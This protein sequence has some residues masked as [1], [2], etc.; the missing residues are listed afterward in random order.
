MG[1][2]SARQ[3]TPTGHPG[4]ITER[5]DRE[6]FVKDL[7]KALVHLYDPTIL[8]H[9]PLVQLFGLHQRR[10]IVSALRSTL[11]DAIERLRPGQGV[12][13]GSQAWRVYHVL[14]YRFT[15]QLSQKEV[16]HDMGLSVRQLRRQENAGLQVLAD[17]LWRLYDLHV[18]ESTLGARPSE[19][20]RDKAPLGAAT[21]S[22]EQEL[23]WLGESL[24]R[25][26]AELQDVVEAALATVRPLLRKAR[27]GVDCTLPDNMPK[28]DVQVPV[29]RQ[30]LVNVLTSAIR[31]ARGGMIHVRAETDKWN[32]RL[33]IRST[34]PSDATPAQE[35]D[36]LEALGMARQLLALFGGSIKVLT[37]DARIQPFAVELSIPATGQ[38]PVLV[39]EDNVDALQL[40]QRCLNGTRYRFVGVHDP[41]RALA[42]AVDS[43]C[44]AIVLDV[45]LPG[46]DGWELMG[47]LRT[48]PQT[49]GVP[50][51]V[52]T[53]LPQEELALALGAAAFIRKPVD[54]LDLLS[55]LDRETEPVLRGSR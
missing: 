15:E 39:I 53:V 46:V 29:L 42:L 8:L 41:E 33:K 38:I 5:L 3:G 9:S 24:P 40:F 26:P 22:R 16:A 1:R 4:D 10:D 44:Q 32:V 13:S 54:R 52:C 2:D 28:L 51:I 11:V 19:V 7:R 14:H 43:S 6:S 34:R 37:G 45:M 49:R 27:A 23:V 50:I 17:V 31:S 55:V 21:P 20:S 30:A 25:E 36:P 47:R 12:P 18:Q 48:H 35:E